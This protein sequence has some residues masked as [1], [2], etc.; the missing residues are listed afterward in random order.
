MSKS[1]NNLRCVLCV[2]AVHIGHT[3]VDA[4][5]DE[6]HSHHTKHYQNEHLVLDELG[7]LYI[8]TP[9]I[10]QTLISHRFVTTV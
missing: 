3:K 5:N 2:N 8:D 7:V 9:Q 10:T 4:E 6:V 1:V